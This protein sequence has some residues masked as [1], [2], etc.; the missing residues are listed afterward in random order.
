MENISYKC[1][2]CGRQKVKLWRPYGD[3]TPLLCASCAENRQSPMEYEEVIWTETKDGYLGKHT[4]K[5]LPLPK[6]KVNHEGFVPS[7]HGPGPKASAEYT[8]DQL[9]VNLKDV[10][11]RYSSGE[12]TLVPAVLA[13]LT[14][15]YSYM[16][17]PETRYQEW[18]KLPN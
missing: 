6:W 3:D 5:M 9:I 2:V 7:W 13:S 18:K 12:T 14:S 11:E 4:G 8:T 16:L 1:S 10:D 15:F 17:I